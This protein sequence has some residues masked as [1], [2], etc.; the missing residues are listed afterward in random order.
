[1]DPLL[2]LM[3]ALANET[4]LEIM[5]LLIRDRQLALHEITKHIHRPYKT[6]AWHLKNLEKAGLLRTWYWKGEVYYAIHTSGNERYNR[7]IIALLKRRIM[8]E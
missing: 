5:Q 2:R 1:M 4:R 3:K 8:Q 6:I 7:Q